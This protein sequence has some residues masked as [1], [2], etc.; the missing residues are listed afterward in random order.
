M[1]FDE[2]GSALGKQAAAGNATLDWHADPR[3]QHRLALLNS[4]GHHISNLTNINGTA[5]ADVDVRGSRRRGAG[6]AWLRAASRG[7]RRARELGARRR[8][9]LAAAPQHPVFATPLSAPPPRRRR[10][11]PASP[12]C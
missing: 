2:D 1:A 11:P 5:Y 10:C 4:T 12:S 6:A 3:L 8:G 7:A 9:S